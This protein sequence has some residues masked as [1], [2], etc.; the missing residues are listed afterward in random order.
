MGR[1]RRSWFRRPFRLD[2]AVAVEEF[3]DGCELHLVRFHVCFVD[4]VNQPGVI[5]ILEVLTR[6]GQ[7]PASDA[8][9]SS[10]GLPLAWC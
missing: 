10:K 7:V 5:Q 2:L 8:L 1:R 3:A 4:P 9:E 6:S